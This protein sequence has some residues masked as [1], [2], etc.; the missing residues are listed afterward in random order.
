MEGRGGTFPV[1]VDY[2]WASHDVKEFA[3]CFQTKAQLEFSVERS[4]VLKSIEFNPLFKLVKCKGN[5][6]VFHGKEDS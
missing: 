3:T 1:I 6:R 2:D 5:E 4:C